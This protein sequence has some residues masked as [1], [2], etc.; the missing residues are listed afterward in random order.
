M[1][2][3]YP[4]GMPE[5]A[6]GKPQLLCASSALIEKGRAVVFDVLLYR[7]PARAFALRYDGVVV[8]YLNRCLHIPTEMDWQPGDFLDSGRE[9]IM[10]SIHGAIYEPLT[11]RC[12]GGPCGGGRLTAI[13]VAECGGQVHWYPSRD[14]QP[15]AGNP[16]GLSAATIP[17]RGEDEPG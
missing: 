9:F 13:A 14:I 15:V 6:Q 5:V 10:C 17:P 12:A 4:R 1:P 16:A 8:A 2:E 7:Q 3:P 11:G